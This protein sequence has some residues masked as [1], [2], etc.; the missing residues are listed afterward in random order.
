VDKFRDEVSTGGATDAGRV[1]ST[2]RAANSLRDACCVCKTSDRFTGG[3]FR[4]WVGGAIGVAV[5]MAIGVTVDLSAG[6]VVG[7]LAD[8]GG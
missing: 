4:G 7:G 2:F 8:G 3:A 1:I 5:G 6:A